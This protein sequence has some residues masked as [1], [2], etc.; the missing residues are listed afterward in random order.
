[1]DD[2][3]EQIANASIDNSSSSNSAENFGEHSELYPES[4][5]NSRSYGSC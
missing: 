5:T 1:M 2:L 3:S 4:G